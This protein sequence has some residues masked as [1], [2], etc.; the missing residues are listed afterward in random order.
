MFYP[1]GLYPKMSLSG[2]RRKT[3]CLCID[4]LFMFNKYWLEKNSTSGPITFFVP[5]TASD[6]LVMT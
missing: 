1:S 3:S 5:L 6:K 4:G 2:T